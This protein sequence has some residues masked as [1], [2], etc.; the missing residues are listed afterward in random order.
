[1]SGRKATSALRDDAR[2]IVESL[3]LLYGKKNELLQ[4]LLLSESDKLYYEKSGNVE[5]V[6]AIIREDERLIDE[7]DLVDC[8]IAGLEQGLSELIGVPPRALYGMLADVP[9]ARDLVALRAGTRDSIKHL[10]DERSA[11]IQR[12]QNASSSVR[13]S[14]D[15]LSRIGRLRRDENGEM[16]PLP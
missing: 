2:S 1:M 14:I 6:V 3:S 7:V 12:L 8:D 9:G 4:T 10:L 13:D 15:E 11:L 16:P 5:R